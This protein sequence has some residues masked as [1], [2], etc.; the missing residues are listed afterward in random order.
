MWRDWCYVLQDLMLLPYQGSIDW[1]IYDPSRSSSMFKLAVEYWLMGAYFNWVS[2]VS[3]FVVAARAMLNLNSLH[4][5][6]GIP[7]D[8][9]RRRRRSVFCFLW[10]SSNVGDFT[11]GEHFEIRGYDVSSRLRSREK[12]QS[13]LQVQVLLKHYRDYVIGLF[14]T[15]S[16]R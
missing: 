6:H 11:A 1:S 2:W 16:D 10:Y 14:I 13:S 4:I 12:K 9:T 3:R 15:V 5:L 8:G 7:P